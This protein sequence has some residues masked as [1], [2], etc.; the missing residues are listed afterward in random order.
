MPRKS[1]VAPTKLPYTGTTWSISRPTATGMR[2][3]APM[4]RF[5]GSNEIQPAP[6]GRSRSGHGSI[7]RLPSRKACPRR[8]S[9]RQDSPIRSARRSHV[10]APRRSGEAPCR[11]RNPAR[12]RGWRWRL[13]ALF[14]TGLIRDP[15]TNPGIQVVQ[16]GNRIRGVPADETLHPIPQPP[17]GIRVM[18]HQKRPEV[19]PLAV[20]IG[21]RKRSRRARDIEHRPGIG[22][23]LDRRAGL[24]D[25]LSDGSEKEALAIAF[26]NTSRA[27]VSGADGVTAMSA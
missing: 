11:G 10:V 4:V 23:V 19:E 2:P 14:I 17:V 26:P 1:L 20:G 13:R 5:V 7:R 27:Q 24:D 18:G 25:R 21:E 3:N 9:C 15:I 16:Q 6:G 8:R 12:G 22:V